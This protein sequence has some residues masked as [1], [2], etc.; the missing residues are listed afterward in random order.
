MPCGSR[1]ANRKLSDFSWSTVF[2]TKAITK[3]LRTKARIG[4]RQRIGLKAKLISRVEAFLI[5]INITVRTLNG[6]TLLLI[7]LRVAL[8]SSEMKL[9]MV[10]GVVNPAIK[11]I[12][13]SRMAMKIHLL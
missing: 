3:P 10:V 9:A 6:T 7:S 13:N 4:S 8:M 2:D 5:K 11:P 12:P 1:P